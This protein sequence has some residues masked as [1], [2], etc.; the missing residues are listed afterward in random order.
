M[1]NLTPQQLE[2]RALLMTEITSPEHL[3]AWCHQ[4]LG[5]TLPDCRV[6]DYADSTPLEFTYECYR[7]IMDGQ[8]LNIIGLSGRDTAKTVSL[9]II[10]LL[11]M[12]HDQRDA[13]HIGMIRQQAQRAREYL[14]NYIQKNEFL[15]SWVSKQNTREIKLMINGQEVGLELISLDP[16]QVQGAHKGL[17]SYDELA[18]SVDPLKMKAYKDSSGIPGSTSK[19][20]PA[21][22]VKITSRQTGNS[23]PEI[24]IKNA[25]KNRLQIRKWTTFDCMKKCEEDRS[26]TVPT[27]MNIHLM[28]GLAYNDEDLKAL[29]LSEQD[30]F[31][32]TE[33]TMDGCVKCPLLQYCQGKA[34]YQVSDSVL[35]RSIDD[36]IHKVNNSG[37]HEWV[38][39]QLMSLQPSAEGLVYSEFNPSVHIP[40]FEVLWTKITGNPPPIKCGRYEVVNELTR[41]GATFIAGV[42]WG[43]TAPSTCV[44]V[45]IHKDNFYIVEGFGMVRKNDPDWIDLIK[46]Q[47]HT[48][49]PVQMYLPD[50]ENPGAI[51]LMRA[52]DLPVA[53]IDKGPGSVKAGV[54]LVKSLLKIPGTNNLSRM[55][56][57]PDIKP[58]SSE[59]PGIIEEFGMYSKDKDAG[60]NVLDDRFIKGNDHYLDALRY[61]IYWYLGK[62]NMR[63][64]FTGQDNSFKP[65]PV[66]P[67]ALQLADLSNVKINDNRKDF[68]SLGQQPDDDDPD[69]GAPGGGLQIAWT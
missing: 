24:E 41:R 37:S 27:P 36:V 5:F 65:T 16:K 54:N 1:D 3:N 14:E 12:I 7:A 49:Y 32:R 57:L 43:Y 23:I 48:K 59:I 4:F 34:R 50:S 68:N 58:T 52:A 2:D 18:S 51:S 28:K 44:V 38:L 61:L 53:E 46:D 39:S 55:F 8:P 20:K 35:L 42:D 10:D 13:I 47:I 9:S 62:A 40:T 33:D 11:A 67:N 64:V 69:D 6:T 66:D 63:A 31:K 21:V 22:V 15:R 29:T 60:G 45:A 26:G 30:G 56:L 17:V 19:G 25:H